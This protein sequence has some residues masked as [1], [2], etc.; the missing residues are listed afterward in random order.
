MTYIANVIL[1]RMIFKKTFSQKEEADT[2]KKIHWKEEGPLFL[3][4]SKSH[5]QQ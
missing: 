5:S 1:E 3:F 2:S 4:Q